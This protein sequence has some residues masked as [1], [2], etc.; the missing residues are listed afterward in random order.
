MNLDEA[1]ARYVSE[2]CRYAK[3]AM[4]VKAHLEAVAGAVGVTASVRAREKDPSSYRAKVVHKGYSDAWSEVTDK[5]GARV[6]VS[7][8]SEVDR[9]V[10][11]LLSGALPVVGDPE[12]KR[13]VTDPDKLAYSGVHLQLLAPADADDP[14][15][16]EC[17]VQ[18]RTAAQD[19]WSVVSHKL[20]YKP[21]VE[22]PTSEQHAVYRLVALMELFDLEVERVSSVIPT[23]PGYEF[24][25][26]LATAEAEFLGLAHAESYRPLSI[27]VLEVLGDAVPHDPDYPQRL[28]TFVAAHR[29]LLVDAIKTYGPSAELGTAYAYTLFSQAE[30][31]IVLE[32]LSD[33]P[34]A[35]AAAWRN[36]GLPSA[37][38][39]A[40]G[41]YCDA[42][43]SA[44]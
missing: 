3:A 31:L 21:V 37:W 27:Q 12:D 30:L 19:A 7:T 18:V 39:E 20:L 1:L 41:T 43:I 35:F 17:E 34:M 42:D 38:L 44:G 25:D 16:I 6:I 4:D 8:P 40:A 11:A 32:R 29:E 2:R 23:L 9:F 28:R 24:R 15:P 5:A 36:S 10:D 26:V 22:L 33:K 13:H 14:E